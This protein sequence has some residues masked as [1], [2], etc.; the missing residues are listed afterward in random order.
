[1][2]RDFLLVRA[3]AQ[4]AC[5][6]FGAGPL[7]LLLHAGGERRSV[8]RPVARRLAQAGFRCVSID[9]RGHGD[10]GGP[11]D[12]LS[13]LV[14]DVCALID[15]LGQNVVLVGSSLGGFVSLS[16]AARRAAGGQVAAVVLIDVVPDPDAEAARTYLRAIQATGSASWN[17]AL[18]ED[19]LSRQAWL[20]AAA[21]EVPVPIALIRGERGL[22]R[23]Q[24][25][26]RLHALVPAL[27]LRCVEGAGHLVAR[28]RPEQL[29]DVLLELFDSL[30]LPE[31][32]L[33]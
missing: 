1:M 27:A 26:T 13:E 28:D 11:G 9:Q 8:W 19:I 4:L 29:S 5:S 20:R 32:R 6:E 21:A 22:V 17:W 25:V 7:V 2:E 30:P 12:K 24:D 15:Q 14:D 18:V 16:S 10:S 3:D 31:W 23:Q 33:R